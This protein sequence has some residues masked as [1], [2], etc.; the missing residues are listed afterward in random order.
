[1]ERR[2]FELRPVSYMA[3][4]LP[5]ELQFSGYLLLGFLTEI[6]RE[7]S[8]VLAVPPT[9]SFR[10]AAAAFGTSFGF[11]TTSTFCG[12]LLLFSRFAAS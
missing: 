3:R 2:E 8:G 10:M 12:F 9:P 1:M 7:P 11:R 6:L 4:V 5:T